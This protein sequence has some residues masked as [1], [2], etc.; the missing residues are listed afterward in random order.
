[1]ADLAISGLGVRYGG[2]HAVADVNLRVM[3]GQ[4]VGLI[5]P[6]GAGKTSV[7]DAVTGFTPAT[8]E[9]LLNGRPLRGCA[10]HVRARR[11]LGRTWQAAELFDAL[12]VEENLMVVERPP[13]VWR[14]RGERAAS[15]HPVRAV[16]DVL[17]SLGLSA[18]R[19]ALPDELS[20]GQRKL[21]GVAR[22]LMAHPAIVLLDEPAAG[23]DTRETGE[24][25]SRLRQIAADGVGVLL[26]D[27]DMG[28]MLEFSD[29]IV[30]LDFGRVIA[31]GTPAEIRANPRVVDAYL[32]V[33]H[34]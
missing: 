29:H 21:V 19:D 32:G 3:A 2:V 25:G 28:L 23:L 10:P 5:G 9:I 14:R 6:N 17:A 34:R 18:V 31:R 30:V 8:G 27:H 33:G 16:D 26:I 4:V 15:A 22:A 20:H 11:G 13:S 24:L 7:V 12:T 1:M